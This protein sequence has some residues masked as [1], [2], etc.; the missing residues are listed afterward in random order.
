MGASETKKDAASEMF[1]QAAK[2]FQT[3][4]EA[5][6]KLQ[7]ESAKSLNELI[8]GLGEPQKWQKQAQETMG[9][10]ATVVQQ[11]ADE[12]MKVVQENTKTSL[13]LLEQAF[14][15]R[16]SE[17][18]ADVQD[19]TREMWET[20]IGAMRRNTEVIVHANGRMVQSWQE[21]AQLLGGNQGN[22]KAGEE[23]D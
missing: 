15:A 18:P 20:A 22:G 14:N 2:M 3:A 5:G 21:M 7:E 6:A 19:R 4:M 10:A 17:K 9:K 8:S 16:Q 12:A 1:G 23:S 13:E 11:N